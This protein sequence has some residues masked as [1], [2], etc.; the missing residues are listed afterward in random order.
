M[1]DRTE[2]TS[3][4]VGG[5]AVKRFDVFADAFGGELSNGAQSLRC[6]AENDAAIVYERAERKPTVYNSSLKAL[7]AA[8]GNQSQ[9]V[10]FQANIWQDVKPDG[11]Q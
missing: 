5:V 1:F 11:A 2:R 10:P 9:Y 7:H 3:L 4:L 6:V 8:L